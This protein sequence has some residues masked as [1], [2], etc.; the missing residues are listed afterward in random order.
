[1]VQVSA[2]TTRST[3]SVGTVSAAMPV[4]SRCH[5]CRLVVTNPRECAR[6]LGE[7]EVRDP[8]PVRHATPDQHSRGFETVEELRH[9]TALPHSRLSED[10]DELR[11]A[12]ALDAGCRETQQGE[13]V[14]AS[15]ERCAATEAARA[16]RCDCVDRLPCIEWKRLALRLERASLPVGDHPVRRL[17]RSFTDEDL[18]GLRKLLETRCD[19][20]GIARHDHLPAR[21]RLAA[22]DH[23]TG[24]HTDS[25]PDFGLVGIGHSGC[26][27]GERLAN[28]ERC[29][30][31]AL[32]VVLV[33]VRNPEHGQDGVADELLGD[34]AVVLDLG[35]DEL[36]EL[37][38]NGRVR[39]RDRA[40]RRGP[41]TRRD[42][43]RG[44]RQLAAPP[45][46]R[47][48]LHVERPVLER[49]PARR[50]ER[51]RRTLLRSARRARLPERRAARLTEALIIGDRRA[52]RDAGQSHRASLDAGLGGEASV[53]AYRD[54]L[55]S[56]AF[57]NEVLER[58]P[59]APRHI[60]QAVDLP[61]GEELRVG[62]PGVGPV[63]HLR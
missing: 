54:P 38:L 36:E 24:V 21:G 43:R 6:D 31:R 49:R 41:S 8:V 19:I 62:T 20:H 27:R 17:A 61:F 40:V 34:P 29:A 44:R 14:V 1:M 47:R 48:R 10:G 42:R 59:C 12:L 57:A 56:K 28:A 16:E 53:R 22:G 51:D 2:A 15:D 23:I 7:R 60:Q 5:V 45:G 4:A 55:L 26:E 25:E 9:E 13:L 63:G 58:S 37:T 39:P 11:A 33:H 46:R 52:T 35:V 3:C 18:S 30:D 32:G 50:T